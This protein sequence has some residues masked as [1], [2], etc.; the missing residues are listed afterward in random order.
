VL[1]GTL[2]STLILAELDHHAAYQLYM[3][4]IILNMHCQNS[5]AIWSKICSQNDKL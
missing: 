1:T 5:K 2:N 3:N 4:Y